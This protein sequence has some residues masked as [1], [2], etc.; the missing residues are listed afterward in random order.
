VESNAAA[1]RPKTEAAARCDLLFTRDEPRWGTLVQ[2]ACHFD[3]RPNPKARRLHRT[4]AAG[5]KTCATN[6]NRS[7]DAGL[8]SCPR[9]GRPESCATEDR[10]AQLMVT[11]SEKAFQDAKDTI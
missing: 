4:Q 7:R 8:Q 5:L 10:G 1:S 2:E 11:F 3:S 9:G 6:V